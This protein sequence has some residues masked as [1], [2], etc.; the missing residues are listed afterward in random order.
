MEEKKFITAKEAKTLSQT[1][2][3]LLNVIFRNIKEEAEMGMYR[4][5]Y[6]SQISEITQ[7]FVVNALQ[8]KGF[9][10]RVSV[11]NDEWELTPETDEKDAETE[12][13]RTVTFVVT[14]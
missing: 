1:P 2:S 8:E 6:T 7:K 5:A 4:Y 3:R 11:S 10:V 9:D 12:E 13:V 14:W